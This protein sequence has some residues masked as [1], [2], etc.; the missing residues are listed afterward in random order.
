M[1]T[2]STAFMQT[3]KDAQTC[4]EI[5]TQAVALVNVRLVATDM[6]DPITKLGWVVML[7]SQGYYLVNPADG[8]RI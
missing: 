8:S 3:L 2:A 4:R 6:P 7:R 1:N 5:T